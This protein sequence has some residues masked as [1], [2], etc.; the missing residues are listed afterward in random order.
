MKENCWEENKCGREP[1]GKKA[2]KRGPCPV[3]TFSL[4]DGYLGGKNGG[5]ACMF[6]VGKLN[7]SDRKMVCDSKLE[8]CKQCQFY[9]KLKAKYKKSFTEPLFEKYIQNAE[10]R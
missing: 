8:D 10:K 9:K 4:A 5:R 2:K 6:I 7:Q 3:P 1:G